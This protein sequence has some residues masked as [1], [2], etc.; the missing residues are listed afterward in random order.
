MQATAKRIAKEFIPVTTSI[1]SIEC[2]AAFAQLTKHEKLYAY[3]MARAAW[4]GSKLCWFQRSYESPA[5]LVLLKL[6]FSSQPIESIKPLLSDELKYQQLLAYSAAVFQ[7]C[8]NYKAFGDSKFVPELDSQDFTQLLQSSVAAQKHGD[9]VNELW[10][11]IEKEV[12]SEED[13]FKILG[14]R[15][16]NGT[17]SYYSSNVTSKDAALLDEFCQ[18]IKL[19][20]LNT[21]LFKISETE[22]DLRIAS[23]EVTGEKTP[24]LKTYP[25]SSQDREITVHVTAGDFSEI[26]GK[27]VQ[28]LEQ[29][30]KYVANENQRNMLRDYIEH[31]RFGD[32]D[33]HK[34]SQRH[35]IKD[36]GPVVETDIGFIET[37]LDPSGARAEFE[38]FVAVV[39]KTTSAKFNQL[40]D[41]AEKLIAKLPWE[42]DFEKDVFQ[43]PDFTNLDVLAFA[44]SDVPIGINIPNYDDIRME[45]GFKNVNLGNAYPRPKKSTLNFL[46]DAD[47]DLLVKYDKDSLTLIVALHELLGHGT[48]K[49]LT[50]NVETGDF[51]FNH[52]DLMN[53]FTHKPIDTYYLS[54]ETWSQKF[55][56]L[57]SGYE[58][59][60][61]DTVAV[62]L[63]HYEE[64]FE[65]FFPGRQGEW[66]DIYYIAWMDMLM[67]GVKGLQFY[68]PNADDVKALGVWGQAHVLASYV[69]LQVVREADKDIVKFQFE[70]KDGKDYFYIDI[71]RSK[72][73]TVAF[74]GI[75]DFLRKL[76]IYKCMGDFE[77]AKAMFDGYSQVDEEMLRVRELVIANKVPRRLNLQPNVQL[78][79]GEPVYKGYEESFEGLIQSFVERYPQPFMEDVYKAWLKDAKAVRRTD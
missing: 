26:M 25:F 24:Y 56:K 31:F 22:F 10:S 62:Y 19:S 77:A 66:D 4:E 48:G 54:S 23:S 51:N 37:Y 49:L 30:Q 16:N 41:D 39:D 55:G 72:L 53:P 67:G 21:R 47:A 63:M 45:L 68:T 1:H 42:K 70:Q 12:Y 36:V 52:T 29:S 76:H 9:I 61:A 38:G 11:S 20:P 14:F 5:L 18:S 13:P 40:V 69:I 6:L 43:K 46:R 35:W 44:C 32:V 50:K 28:E 64:P 7:N 73:K 57:H 60:R 78:H 8:G 59:C 79:E 75:S 2:P 74:K 34:D 65:I 33:K 58:E 3:H 15:D 17:T 71:D 27:L